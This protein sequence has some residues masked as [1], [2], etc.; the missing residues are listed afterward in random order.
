MTSEPCNGKMTENFWWKQLAMMK[1]RVGRGHTSLMH[2]FFP[3]GALH[4]RISKRG[5]R[6]VAGGIIT[7]PGLA[8]G[9]VR[10][11]GQSLEGYTTVS[12][13][14]SLELR[15]NSYRRRARK[16][17]TCAACPVSRLLT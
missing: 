17:C 11:L 2:P 3:E 12:K 13:P 14:F 6:W 9:C 4:C 5:H 16:M 7:K 8:F 10:A 1:T 15:T